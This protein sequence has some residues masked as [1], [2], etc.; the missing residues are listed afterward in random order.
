M[1][2]EGDQHNKTFND[3]FVYHG[4]NAE[5]IKLNQAHGSMNNLMP[6]YSKASD[7]AAPQINSVSE[8]N[9]DV[10]TPTGTSND[11]QSFD[12]PRVSPLEGV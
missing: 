12:E 4:V 7:S 8:P 10:I 1:P 3:I 11:V 2:S 6:S 5:S 9:F